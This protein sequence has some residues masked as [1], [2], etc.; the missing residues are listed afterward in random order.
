MGKERRKTADAAE[1]AEGKGRK[2]ELLWKQYQA[3]RDSGWATL[4]QEKKLS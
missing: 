1:W 2:K 4:F 3:L